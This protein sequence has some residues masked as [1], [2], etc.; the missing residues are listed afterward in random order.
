VAPFSRSVPE[1]IEFTTEAVEP[2]TARMDDLAAAGRGW[3]NLLPEVV[4]EEGS[5]PPSA[6]G[7]LFRATGPPVPMATWLAPQQRRDRLEPATVGVQHGAG[8]RALERLAEGGLGLPPGWAQVQDHTRRG[9]VVRVAGSAAP[10][11]VLDWMLA[12]VGL[13]CPVPLTGHW[14]AEVYSHGGL[15]PRMGAPPP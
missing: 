9:L 11:A 10:P 1:Q 3:M 14:L 8:P 4:E 12:A 6:I 2:V 7:S 15:R 5:T 13:L